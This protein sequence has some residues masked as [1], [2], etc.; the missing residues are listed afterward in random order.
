[1][2]QGEAT[3][4]TNQ[5]LQ[6]QDWLT[7]QNDQYTRL[8]MGGQAM[9]TSAGALSSAAGQGIQAAEIPYSQGNAYDIMGIEN[10]FMQPFYEASSQSSGGGGGKK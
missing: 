6:Y 5:G 4:R 10:A 2:Q 9:N 7:H 3:Q 1:M 8:G